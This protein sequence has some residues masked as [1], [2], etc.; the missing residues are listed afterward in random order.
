M[1]RVYGTEHWNTAWG[2]SELAACLVAEGHL[3]EAETLLRAS[4]PLLRA[5]KGPDAWVTQRA[6][7]RVR[8]LYQALGKPEQAV[9]MLG[10]GS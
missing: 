5:R 6:R 4:Y 9:A 7:H 1:A 2:K 10:E 8:Q 3:G